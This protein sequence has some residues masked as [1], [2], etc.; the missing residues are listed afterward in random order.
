[1]CRS[2]L[3]LSKIAYQ[4]WHNH[5]FFQRNWTTER[6]VGVGVGDDREWGGLDKIWKRGWAIS[7]GLHKIGGLIHVYR[8]C[9]GT[10]KISHPPIIKPTPHSWLPPI[11]TMSM[12]IG[13]WGSDYASLAF[14]N[15]CVF[16]ILTPKLLGVSQRGWVS[17]PSQAPSGAWTERILILL[18]R[19]KQLSHYPQSLVLSKNKY[20]SR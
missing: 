5:P 15:H 13:L 14:Y 18:Q 2:I 16:T 8:L 12:P 1:M 9:K 17:T 7:G 11:R 3:S 20:F 4:T 19:L 6:T 10:F